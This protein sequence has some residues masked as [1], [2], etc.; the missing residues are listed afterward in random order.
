[1]DGAKGAETRERVMAQLERD[2]DSACFGH[3]PQPGFGLIVREGGR[4][5]FRAL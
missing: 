5:I 2:G 4:R 3:F 1:V